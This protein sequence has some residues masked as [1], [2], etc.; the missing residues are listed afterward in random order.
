MPNKNHTEELL[1]GEGSLPLNKRNEEHSWLGQWV[2]MGWA[3]R[4]TPKLTGL[5]WEKYSVRAGECWDAVTRNYSPALSL[6]LL[7]ELFPLHSF[8]LTWPTCGKRIMHAREGQVPLFTVCGAQAT[9][10]DM[11]LRDVYDNKVALARCDA[12]QGQL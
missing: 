2:K 4:I 5:D 1:V 7:S 8:S 3:I 6:A 12:H 9:H 11:H 10:T